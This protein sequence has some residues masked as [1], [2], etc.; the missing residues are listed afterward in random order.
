[1]T[2]ESIRHDL[3]APTEFYGGCPAC[4]L[5]RGYFNI[6]RCHWGVCDRHQTKW[7]VGENLFPSWKEEDETT[8]QKNTDLLSNHRTARPIYPRGGDQENGILIAIRNWRAW[9][10]QPFGG[11]LEGLGSEASVKFSRE[12][13]VQLLEDLE[14]VEDLIVQVID[15]EFL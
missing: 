6:G 7:L 13:F 10:E 12:Q 15:T 8:W 2:A 3:P 4:G 9:F 14:A 5:C 1:M 11:D